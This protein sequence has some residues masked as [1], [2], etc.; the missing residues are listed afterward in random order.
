VVSTSELLALAMPPQRSQTKNVKDELHA[1]IEEELMSPSI[2]Q[3]IQNAVSNV[4][5]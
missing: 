3:E 5:K 4:K 2:Q 1:I